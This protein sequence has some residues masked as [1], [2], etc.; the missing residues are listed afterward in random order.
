[1]SYIC[2]IFT[3]SMKSIFTSILLPALSAGLILFGASSCSIL[4]KNKSDVKKGTDGIVTNEHTVAQPVKPLTP[5]KK[6]HKKPSASASTSGKQTKGVK[7]KHANEHSTAES[8]NK[9]E[10]ANEQA[11]SPTHREAFGETAGAQ[12]PA[13]PAAATASAVIPANFTINGEWII[14]SVRGNKVTGDERPYVNFDLEAKRFYGSNGCNIINGD[15]ELKAKD[16]MHLYNI[17]AT[18]RLCQDADFEYLIN[19]ALSDVRSYAVRQGDSGSETFLDLKGDNG[20]VLLI[21]RRHNMDF[22]NGAWRIDT[23]NGTTLK[24]ENDATITIDIPD[25]KIHGCTGCN[26]FNGKLFID[27][28]KNRSMQFAD[29]ATTRMACDKASRETELLLALEEV[30]HARAVATDKVEFYGRKGNVLMTLTRLD[31]SDKM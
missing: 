12:Q 10:A 31:L 2:K 13:K 21:L 24:E 28:D 4:S 17:I 5:P 27:P 26:I 7:N 19:L 8:A 1:M 22:L 30:E 23:L 6:S 29:I 16:A 3:E 14:Y 11:V 20:T 15:L 9:K 18:T 25:L